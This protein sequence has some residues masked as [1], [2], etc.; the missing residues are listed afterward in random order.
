M[1]GL[2]VS[3][4]KSQKIPH[5]EGKWYY[6]RMKEVDHSPS[7]QCQEEYSRNASSWPTSHLLF[8][9]HFD[10]RGAVEFSLRPVR[11]ASAGTRSNMTIKIIALLCQHCNNIFGKA[12]RGRTRQYHRISEAFAGKTKR[13]FHRSFIG[14]WHLVVTAAL[15]HLK[16]RSL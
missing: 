7:N 5:C 3:N 14:Y 2:S 13:K 12:F 15:R 8:V 6:E 16:M 10:L 9:I 4:V 11:K 1:L